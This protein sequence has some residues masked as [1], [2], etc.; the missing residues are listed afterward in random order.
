M[1]GRLIKSPHPSRLVLTGV[2]VVV[3][4]GLESLI[5]DVSLRPTKGNSY[6]STVTERLTSKKTEESVIWSDLFCDTTVLQITP[7]ITAPLVP[8]EGQFLALVC[9]CDVKVFTVFDFLTLSD[10]LIHD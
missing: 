4:Y 7:V 8:G 1:I 9:V 3:R 2:A 10:E 5:L 6:F